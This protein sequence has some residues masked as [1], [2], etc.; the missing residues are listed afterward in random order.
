M[1]NALNYASEK[2]TASLEIL[3]EGDG[4]LKER[5][6]DAWVSQFSRLDGFDMPSEFQ[7]RFDVMDE[8]VSRHKAVGNE[9]S[10]AASIEKLTPQEARDLAHRMVHFAL[11]LEMKIGSER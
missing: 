9:G 6:I 4:S 5:L 2:A 11:D 7:K 3:A 8:M 1:N 10:I